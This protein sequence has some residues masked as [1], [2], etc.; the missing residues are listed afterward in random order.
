[1]NRR[2]FL[3]FLGALPFAPEMLANLPV[4]S[5]TQPYEVVISTES[6]SYSTTPSITPSISPSPTFSTSPSHEEGE[7]A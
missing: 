5:P 6:P 4:T 1:M 3:K 7:D 2:D